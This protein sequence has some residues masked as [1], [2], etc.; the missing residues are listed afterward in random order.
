MLYFIV[1]MYCFLLYV[2]LYNWAAYLARTLLEKSFYFISVRFSSGE[3][4]HYNKAILM[5]CYFN[6]FNHNECISNVH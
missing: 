3:I 6:V 4:K 1:V 5:K 2:Y